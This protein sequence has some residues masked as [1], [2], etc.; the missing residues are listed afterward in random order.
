MWTKFILY[1]YLLLFGKKLDRSEKILIAHKVCKFMTA[2]LHD[3]REIAA[4][5]IDNLR[6]HNLNASLLTD[7]CRECRELNQFVT[8]LL[9]VNI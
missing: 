8:Y 9:I 3:S 6:A 2:S 1:S 4:R 5:K 7:K